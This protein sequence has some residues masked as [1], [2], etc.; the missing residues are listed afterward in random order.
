MILLKLVVVAIFAGIQPSKVEIHSGIGGQRELGTELILVTVLAQ[1]QA[2]W[3]T[4][5]Q[6]T[7][8]FE[9]RLPERDVVLV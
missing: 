2:L 3:V 9:M 8:L 7:Q 1:I 4:R 6:I 5:E